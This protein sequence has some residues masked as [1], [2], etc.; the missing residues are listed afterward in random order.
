M[1]LRICT[2]LLAALIAL[3]ALP[4][5][6]M[7]DGGKQSSA[8]AAYKAVVAQTAGLAALL[9][10][11]AADS[12]ALSIDTTGDEDK[13]L[14]MGA[15]GSDALSV[16]ADATD[17][18]VMSRQD[19]S[20]VGVLLPGTPDN[21]KAVGG[22]MVLFE[23][24]DK[25][26]DA[27]IQAQEDSGVRVLTVIKGSQ[28]PTAFDYELKLDDG[29]KLFPMHDGRVAIA[30]TDGVVAAV[31]EAPWAYDASGSAISASYTTSD[32]VLTLNVAHDGSTVYPVL[33]D[34]VFTW[35]YLSGTVYFDRTETLD[36]AELSLIP[37]AV[38]LILPEPVTT[39]IALQAAHDY[40][41]GGVSDR[42]RPHVLEAAIRPSSGDGLD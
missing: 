8:E 11:T 16:P 39:L 26:T 9:N 22:N 24:V 20:S 35:G 19:G 29:Y 13:V 18:I 42:P 38:F 15:E 23:D 30:D 33:A 25:D 36:V 28:A 32:N 37:I 6:A 2:A 3:G 34:P 31:I 4:S 17:P 1:R 27:L 5:A 41:L 40:R 21:G 10:G 7:A 14:S 12:T